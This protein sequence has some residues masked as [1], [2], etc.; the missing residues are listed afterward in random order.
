MPYAAANVVLQKSRTLWR[1][2][3][4]TPDP[5]PD[6]LVGLSLQPDSRTSGPARTGASAPHTGQSV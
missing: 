5:Q 6:A 3:G 1:E 4:R 2:V